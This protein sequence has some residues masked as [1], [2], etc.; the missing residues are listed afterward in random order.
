M[1]KLEGSVESIVFR[2]EDNQYTVARF[3][4][5]DSGRLFR[6]DLTTI[7]GTLPGVHVGELLVVEGEWEKDP[8]Y[9]RQLHVMSFIQRLPASPEGITRYLSSGLIKGIGPK[10]AKLIVDHFG[11]QTLAIIE[12]QP[13]QLGEVKG[14]SAKDREQII[15][16]WAEQS[17][18][19]ELHL[20][21]QTHDVSM[22]IATRIYKQYGQDAIKVVRENPYQLAQEVTGIGFRTADDIAIKLGLP[23]DSIPRLATG[24]K[25]VLAQ[26]ANDDGHCFLFEND[27]L[28]RAARI[29]QA[30]YE[31]LPEAL[32]QLCSEKDIFIEP[33]LPVE[34]QSQ[35]EKAQRN[36]SY[37]AEED[38]P[39][40]DWDK[41]E[42]PEPQNRVYFGP[43]WYAEHG[44]ARLLRKFMRTP[45]ILP[46]VS[47]QYWDTVF[48][49]LAQNRNMHLT[50][51]QR[52]AVQM[53]YKQKVSILTGG[54]GTGKSTSLRA[55]LMM[56]R[57]RKVEVALTAPT[58]RAAKRLT[59]ATGAI[60]FQAK[61]LHRLLEY[62]PHDNSYQRNEENP[63]PYQ[64]VIVDEFSMVDILLFYH[65][66]KA[67]PPDAHLMLVGDADQL[68]SVGPGNVLRDLLRS[69]AIP[70]VVLMELFRQAQQS[71]IIVNAH[72]INAGHMPSLKVE[73]K[74]DFFFFKEEDPVRAQQLI[75]DLVQRR[76]P[77]RFHFNALTDIQVLSPMYKGAV[78]VESL[79]EELQARLNPQAFA[80][81][82]WGGRVLRVGDK[83]MQVRN[84][85][86]KGVFNGDVGW[87]RAINKENS[88][89]KIE[90][91]EEAGPLLV[92]YDFHE[93]DE[94]VLA[95]AI[96]VH[97]SQGSEYPAIIV[98]LVTQHAML[99]QRNLLY[100]AITRA[101]RLCILVGQPRALEMAVRNNRVA[102]RNTG[103]AERLEFYALRGTL[104]E[105]KFAVGDN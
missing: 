70:T 86:D 79:N 85:Y 1:P 89:L 105:S 65:L 18:I 5:N 38:Y 62:A 54:P 28:Q 2:N 27:L 16:T 6:D 104:Y 35:I 47:Q 97:K 19:K 42:E 3:R 63:L 29:L 50:E 67:L 48:D 37:A 11:E 76:I 93:L 72:Q 21:L 92:S 60:G 34:Q 90:F 20:F 46:P 57:K 30:P 81:L 91:L 7:V 103:L 31:A 56:L 75:L 9:G 25:Y 88:T 36:F 15:K 77:E 69:K 80:E 44:S 78:G 102:M 84:N 87:I 96:T 13:E 24:L 74:S 33:P 94:L 95:Y 49:F 43:F 52:E 22:N 26:A 32:E 99:L 12:Q 83:V 98:P 68:P 71:R 17:D 73:P 40:V 58:G 39:S 45:S 55:L 51:K 64:F 4:P 59:E 23:R 66:L 41:A 14:I 82:E 53:A 101:K 61:T 10:K 100:T 8:K